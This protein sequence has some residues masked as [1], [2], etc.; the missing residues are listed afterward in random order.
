MFF[1]L[2]DENSTIS[3]YDLILGDLSEILPGSFPIVEA[4]NRISLDLYDNQIHTIH[5]GAWVVDSNFNGNSY[6]DKPLK[7]D[8]FMHMNEKIKKL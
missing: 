4:S 7:E 8:W 2:V 6:E 1:F 3:S 5:P